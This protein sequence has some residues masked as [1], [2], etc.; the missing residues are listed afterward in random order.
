MRPIC[1]YVARVTRISDIIM[2]I[3]KAIHIAQSGTPGPVFVEI[4]VDI[5]Y[6]YKMIMKEMKITA[7]KSLRQVKV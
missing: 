6:S 2:V 3:K 4:P 5:L 1:K 7:A